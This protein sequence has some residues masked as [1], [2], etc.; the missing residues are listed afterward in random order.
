MQ[1]V[2]D[3]DVRGETTFKALNLGEGYGL[4]RNLEPDKRPRSRDVVI[5][6]PIPNEL[7]R[8]AGIISTVGQTPLSYVNLHAL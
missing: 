7:P 4:L 1:L 2:F 5:Y 3:E 6:E 8:V